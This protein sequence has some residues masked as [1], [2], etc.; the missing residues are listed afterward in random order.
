MGG[1]KFKVHQT[2]F[3][4]SITSESLH[5]AVGEFF[6]QRRCGHDITSPITHFLTKVP[7]PVSVRRLEMQLGE[8]AALLFNSDEY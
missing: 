6:F 2:S 5:T 1:V 4:E 8:A 3:T 7:G